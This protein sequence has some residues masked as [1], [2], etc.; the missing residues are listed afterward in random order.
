MGASGKPEKGDA[1]KV[2]LSDK[3]AAN[4]KAGPKPYRLFDGDGLYLEISPRAAKYW[5]L[6][7]R[8]AGK[9]KRLALGVYP[10]VGLKTARGHSEEARKLL[11]NGVDPGEHR[12]VA[13]ANRLSSAANSFES[14]AL[15]W[16]LRKQLVWAACH[17]TRVAALLKRDLY[18]W[19]GSRPIGAITPPELLASLRRIESRG[20]L[21]TTKRARIV[22][23]QVFRF[24]V[25]TGRAER[26]PSSD[27]RGAITPAIKQHLAAIIEP[28]KAGK[29]LL[30]IDHYVGTPVVRAALRLAPLVFVRPGELRQARWSE[31]DLDAAEWRIPAERMKMRQAHLV[32]LAAKAVDIL[33]DLRPLTGHSDFVF[34]SHRSPQRPMSE[35][36]ILVALRALG[37]TNDEMTGHGFRAMARTMMD[38]VLHYRVDLIEHQLAH[39]VRDPNGRAYNR[40][41]HLDERKKMMQGWADYLD[42]LQLQAAGANVVALKRAMA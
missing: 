9:E 3:A 14:V 2:A 34:P 8:Y 32:P 25:A 6:K 26:D 28:K 7:Y 35:N 39:A 21:E 40:T 36:A 29:L 42:Q 10:E 5:R 31:F 27:L 4:A 12:K 30:A 16:L 15:E 13:R 18:P 37:Y 19:I 23:G 17:W 22:A 38:E 41:A 24:A 1:P 11:R 20:A 33:R